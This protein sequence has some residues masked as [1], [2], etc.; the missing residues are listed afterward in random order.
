MFTNENTYDDVVTQWAARYQVPVWVIKT[1]IG[2]ESGFDKRAF[3][4]DDPGTGARGLMQILE[5]TARDLG[6]KGTVG[7]DNTRTAGLYEP[8][9]NV[10]LG[11][12]YLRQLYDRYPGETWDRI[13]AAYNAGH[14]AELDNGALINQPNVDGWSSIAD[15][16]SPG[17]RG[18]GSTDA[19]ADPTSPA[20]GQQT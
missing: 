13:Y 12:K 18:A 11:T 19:G 7:D 5:G 1:T 3:N 17:W 20:P 9:L 2:K 15:Y 6:L 16:F 8:A 10:Q 4:D 14:I